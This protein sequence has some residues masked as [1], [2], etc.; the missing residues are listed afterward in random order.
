MKLSS[1]NNKSSLKALF[2]KCLW[3]QNFIILNLYFWKDIFITVNVINSARILKTSGL[4]NKNKINTRWNFWV[5]KASSFFDE[6]C[7]I[8]LVTE[9]FYVR[10]K[11]SYIKTPHD[12]I[13]FITWWIQGQTYPSSLD[14]HE[15][16]SYLNYKNSKAIISFFGGWILRK[17][18]PLIFFYRQKFR[19]DIFSNKQPYATS[20]WIMIQTVWLNKPF[21]EKLT[22]WKT[23]V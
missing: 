9:T 1:W 21:Y 12:N 19:G 7:Q 15:Y 2:W 4:D 16:C 10:V 3:S 5:F 8:E 11:C 22:F 20:F 17:R 14:G 23:L 6:V 13:I 18:L